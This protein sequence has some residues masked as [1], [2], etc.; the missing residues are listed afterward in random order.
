MYT[1]LE[2]YT[3]EELLTQVA[4]NSKTTALELELAKRLARELDK[5]EDSYAQDARRRS[6]VRYS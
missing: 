1:G 2:N 6:Q 4:V 5:D 3:N